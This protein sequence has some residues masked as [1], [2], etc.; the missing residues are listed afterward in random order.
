[1]EH[2]KNIEIK[3]FKSIRDAKINDCRRV[4][5][6]IGPPNV[7]KSNIL[8][9]MGLFSID[10]ES[11]NFCDFVRMGKCT[12]MFFN[13]AIENPVQVILNNYFRVKIRYEKGGLSASFQED[14]LNEGFENVDIEIANADIIKISDAKNKLLGKAGFTVS[15][16]NK[17]IANY[18]GDSELRIYN[19]VVKDKAHTG[20]SKK[21]PIL[22]YEFKKNIQYNSKDAWHLKHPFGENIF[23]IISTNEELRN[24]IIDI[25]RSYN[26]DFLHDSES[27]S[28]KILKFINRGIFGIPY[29]MIA[30]T[31]QR[32]IFHKAAIASNSNSVLLFEEPEAHMFPPYI[33][34]LT[35]DIVSD[36]NNKQ[37]FITT[38]SP[39]VLNDL[40]EE[41]KE[42]QLAI[43]I[44][45]YKKDT[46]E[47][48]INRMNKEE[49]HEAY[50]FGYDFFLNMKNFIP[51]S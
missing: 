33:S 43:Y 9:A 18:E 19:S 47:T 2:I 30:D 31:L 41:L 7:G 27:Q 8:E 5:I 50:Q 51:V 14:R 13:G 12:T 6:F 21:I 44:V 37:Y 26:L 16:E 46:G 11:I 38:H 24:S 28:Y 42:D 40:M 29:S 22:K 17:Q 49:M 45:S 20:S 23:E 39:F 10:R 1:L 35:G 32:L 25:L 3:N 36:E 4:N 48:L 34:K 15:E